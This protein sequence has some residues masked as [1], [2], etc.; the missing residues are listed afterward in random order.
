M[1]INKIFR[2]SATARKV[3]IRFYAKKEG[4]VYRS[5][6][7]RRL[8]VKY[9]SID[10]GYGS[11][12]WTSDLIDGPTRIGKYTSIGKNVRR[13]SVDHLFNT[14]TTHP[15]LFSPSF[16]WVNH[17]ARER[18]HLEIGNDVWIGDNAI[19]LPSVSSIGDGAIVAA[20]AVVSRNIPSYEIWGGTGSLHKK[21]ISG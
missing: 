16:G 12:G 19:I 20:G 21:K 8:F 13:I 18:M 9:K 15:C 1:L 6:T 2:K 3:I 5:Q 4:G 10:A 17:D 11:Y 7:I 14:A